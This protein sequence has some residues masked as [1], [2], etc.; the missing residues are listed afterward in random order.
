MV[1]GVGTEHDQIGYADYQSGH[2]EQKMTRE[3]KNLIKRNNLQR[4]VN[5]EK[6]V[7][8]IEEFMC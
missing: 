6:Y 2:Q 4:T 5:E 7:N 1:R 8:T 3:T